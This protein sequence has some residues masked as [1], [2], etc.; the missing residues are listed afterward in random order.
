[1]IE[2]YYYLRDHYHAPR[3]TIC[4]LKNDD[5]FV[6]RGIAVCSPD[7]NPCKKTGR[8]IALAQARKANGTKSNHPL[9]FKEMDR[10]WIRNFSKNFLEG[11]GVVMEYFYEFN[12]KLTPMELRILKMEN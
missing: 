10:S 12:P 9:K 7:D 11:H 5:G 4:L 1:M 3:I 6:S 8:T 2:R